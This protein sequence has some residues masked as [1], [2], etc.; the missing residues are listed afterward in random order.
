[1]QITLSAEEVKAVF[2]ISARLRGSL[3]GSARTAKKAKSC[4]KNG[5]LHAKAVL[6]DVA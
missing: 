2:K 1:M 4:R 3:G 6:K 5:K